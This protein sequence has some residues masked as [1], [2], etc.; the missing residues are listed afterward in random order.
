MSS[1][2][3]AAGYGFKSHRKDSTWNDYQA[4]RTKM[5]GEKQRPNGEYRNP[6]YLNC[7]HSCT[8]SLQAFVGRLASEYKAVMKSELGENWKNIDR[9]RELAKRK[10]WVGFA[11][12]L[13]EDMASDE[14]QNRVK[15]VTIKRCI[16]EV[17]KVVSHF[18]ST[19]LRGGL[20]VTNL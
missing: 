14:R 13:R 15:S 3:Q 20:T 11:Q 18:L 5:Q 2:H 10:G 12:Q 19:V 6:A 1:L 4:F 17:M 16:D 9:R 7:S 8:E